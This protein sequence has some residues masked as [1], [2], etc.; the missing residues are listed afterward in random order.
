LG[1]SRDCD[2][3]NDSN[4]FHC[5]GFIAIIDH[6]E[7]MGN[8]TEPLYRC[9]N[10][11]AKGFREKFDPMSIALDKRLGLPMKGRQSRFGGSVKGARKV[12][13]ESLDTR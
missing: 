5:V 3:V 11:G 8:V 7:K 12:L 10:C 13:Q 6:Y 9:D 2:A 4:L 1:H